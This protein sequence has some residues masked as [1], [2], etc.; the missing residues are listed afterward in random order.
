MVTEAAEKKGND[1]IYVGR[2]DFCVYSCLQSYRQSICFSLT[3][4][5]FLLFPLLLLCA[6]TSDPQDALSK[7]FEWHHKALCVCL[8]F[9][10]FQI[11]VCIFF[12]LFQCMNTFMSGSRTPNILVSCVAVGIEQ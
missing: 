3:N 11:H 4:P 7:A 9:V 10:Q 1:N 8:I 12:S 6:A 2:T 5:F